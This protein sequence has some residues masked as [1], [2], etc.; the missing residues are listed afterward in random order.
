MKVEKKEKLLS[1]A[2]INVNHFS[3]D[4]I[5]FR[6]CE[7]LGGGGNGRVY[8]IVVDG[9][10]EEYK[11]EPLVVKVF[12]KTVDDN[13]EVDRRYCRFR[14]EVLTQKGLADEGVEGIIPIY[15]YE[16]PEGKPLVLNDGRTL[17]EKIEKMMDIAL[18]L[19]SIHN[20]EL[21]HRDVKYKNM[22]Y[23]NDRLCLADFGLIWLGEDDLTVEGE[24][25]GPHSILPKELLNIKLADNID[26]TYSD[27][28]LFA[29]TFWQYLMRQDQ[30]F[31]NEYK[32]Y[33]ERFA[34]ENLGS[35][36][37]SLD[38][39][40][41]MLEKA[42]KNEWRERIDISK[43]IEYMKKQ[44]C[45]LND[46]GY[47]KVVEAPHI[48]AEDDQ[49]EILTIVSS[50]KIQRKMKDICRGS[51]IDI[52][53]NGQEK[54]QFTLDHVEWKDGEYIMYDIDRYHRIRVRVR[55]INLNKDKNRTFI[56]CE[57]CE[58]DE[59]FVSV[60]SFDYSDYNRINNIRIDVA[61]QMEFVD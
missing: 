23:Y 28:Y 36:N 52:F 50:E 9:G 27:V 13:N 6:K 53:A 46:A 61:A 44:I 30:I 40:H 45:V 43:C 1:M 47:G 12:F 31:K 17:L 55:S 34:L 26:F 48:L 60:T 58:I 41:E 2:I 56:E 7:G 15:T 19:Q 8:K 24:T 11:T 20:R 35:E 32:R 3:N 10:N 18:A 21:A 37:V 54:I 14:R 16:L 51:K 29:K 59:Q 33:D 57:P 5:S 38:A 22:L 39:L 25:V 42:T 49:Y 4:E